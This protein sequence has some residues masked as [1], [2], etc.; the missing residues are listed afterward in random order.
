[1][2]KEYPLQTTD[3]TSERQPSNLGST[4]V[5]S[6]E[7]APPSPQNSNPKNDSSSH[8]PG[9]ET[10]LHNSSL[11]KF[12]SLETTSEAETPNG[13]ISQATGNIQFQEVLLD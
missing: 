12:D 4:I 2:I 6:V 3:E 13:K 9:S 7:S 5:S 8:G 1:M 11:T 10:V